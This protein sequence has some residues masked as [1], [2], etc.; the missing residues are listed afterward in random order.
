MDISGVV[1][2]SLGSFMLLVEAFASSFI[3]LSSGALS[4][5]I[6]RAEFLL[7]KAASFTPHVNKEAAG[8]LERLEAALTTRKTLLSIWQMKNH[9]DV[10][11]AK[12]ACSL[13]TRLGLTKYC[14]KAR[15][16]ITELEA[17][18]GEILRDGTMY[19][20]VTLL[21]LAI[22][23]FVEADQPSLES[24]AALR[25]EGATRPQDGENPEAWAEV[26]VDLHESAR[27]LLTKVLSSPKSYLHRT[28]FTS[29]SSS[30]E[31]RGPQGQ[32]GK[33][34]W[35]EGRDLYIFGLLRKGGPLNT[36]M[37]KT[38]KAFRNHWNEAHPTA[39]YKHFLSKGEYKPTLTNFLRG[40]LESRPLALEGIVIPRKDDATA[41]SFFEYVLSDVL[42][43]PAPQS[44]PQPPA[45]QPQPPQPPQ[46]GQSPQPP[47]PPQPLGNEMMKRA[48]QKWM[49]LKWGDVD[50]NWA[51][52]T[53][54]Q[55]AGKFMTR[56]IREVLGAVP[57]KVSNTLEGGG[58]QEEEGLVLRQN[59]LREAW[60]GA[61]GQFLS[62]KFPG[63]V[64][65]EWQNVEIQTV[66]EE[67]AVLFCEDQIRFRVFRN[68][69]PCSP[70][71]Q[72]AD[73]AG[74]IMA[75]PIIKRAWSIVH[76]VVNGV[77]RHA[78]DI[79]RL[80]RLSEQRRQGK[81]SGQ[82]GGRQSSGAP[83]LRQ[84]IQEILRAGGGDA[85][86]RL[87]HSSEAGPERTPPMHH[88]TRTRSLPA[89]PDTSSD[90]SSQEDFADVILRMKA[91]GLVTAAP[92]APVVAPAAPGGAPAPAPAPAPAAP[93]PR[94]EGA[95]R[96]GHGGDARTDAGGA[97][98]PAPGGTAPADK[99]VVTALGKL[100]DAANKA[101]S[102]EVGGKDLEAA[103]RAID[104]I[105]ARAEDA[106]R[107]VRAPDR[108][109]GPWGG[110][111]VYRGLLT[112]FV[113][114]AGGALGRYNSA[115]ATVDALAPVFFAL[116]QRGAMAY[117]D[118]LDAPQA[119]AVV[120]AAVAMAAAKAQLAV[121]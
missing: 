102:S 5:G 69:L 81:D 63:D 90:T 67:A 41:A 43:Q 54:R 50:I 110:G 120:H 9:P 45:P 56:P 16:S 93:A 55:L 84:V 101:V 26:M 89:N 105:T 32:V 115:A 77:G 2:S 87:A 39:D 119:L 70:P 51:D 88:L 33:E 113:R 10:M 30:T 114:A 21:G 17:L 65:A 52:P 36:Q 118:S 18:P 11:R 116:E 24:L 7:K 76:N 117:L 19:V 107:R 121:S 1:H 58:S 57:S 71:A 28:T 66:F 97:A 79:R 98:A 15:E 103:I 47:Q 53:A 49:W 82:R 73:F 104:D 83:D 68:S 13:D 59:L 75:V 109:L 60:K 96:G 94:V 72:V 99:E 35:T 38:L 44:Q 8:Y 22:W 86:G 78:R 74:R 80:L 46:P 3:D 12:S 112:R 106:G 100:A 40:L 4:S 23:A 34:R 64:P 27:E 62:K 61:W 31:R 95:R 111:K 91:D 20:A 48:A 92:A 85:C 37:M 108:A 29:L 25:R 6:Q 42:K 14:E